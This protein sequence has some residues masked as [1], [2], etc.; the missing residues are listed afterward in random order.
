MCVRVCRHYIIW[1]FFP[2]PPLNWPI[3]LTMT[4]FKLTSHDKTNSCSWWEGG[5]LFCISHSWHQHEM[6]IFKPSRY[7]PYRY[8][9]S[10]AHLSYC[11]ERKRFSGSNDGWLCG[12][13][14]VT[15]K[16]YQIYMVGNM[17]VNYLF[18]ISPSARTCF[19]PNHHPVHAESGRKA[20]THWEVILI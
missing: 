4:L 9:S 6:T 12:V 7:V 2:P 16:E 8:E 19:K 3:I 14:S 11:Q 17:V 10:V 18:S 13:S 15:W 20:F 1:H 5:E